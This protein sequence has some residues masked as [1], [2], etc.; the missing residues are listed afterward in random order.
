MVGVVHVKHHEAHPTANE[1]SSPQNSKIP[2][3]KNSLE[4]YATTVGLSHSE[5]ENQVART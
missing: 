5:Y 3:L 1:H 4:N 2:L